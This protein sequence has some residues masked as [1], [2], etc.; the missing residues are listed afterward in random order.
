M[1]PGLPRPAAAFPAV[2]GLIFCL[3]ATLLVL[4]CLAG[5][6]EGR[7]HWR[8][9]PAFQALGV[10]AA[11]R[12]S[13]VGL[14]STPPSA[15]RC[16]LR[17]ANRERR[18]ADLRMRVKEERETSRAEEAPEN[19]SFGAL[20]LAATTPGEVVEASAA[21]PWDAGGKKKRKMYRN[22]C[23]ALAKLAQMLTGMGVASARDATVREPGFVHVCAAAASAA[24]WPQP[25][26]SHEDSC[27]MDEEDARAALGALRALALLAPLHGEALESARAI[28]SII[29]PFA[30]AWPPHTVSAA[31]WAAKTL[32]LD[33]DLAE[34]QPLAQA[35]TVL[36]LPFRISPSM[37]SR[38]P[39]A[40]EN[41]GYISLDTLRAEIPFK[42][43]KLVT[44][45]GTMVEERRAT[46]WMAEDGV[47]GLACNARL[48]PVLLCCISPPQNL[49]KQA[50]T[51]I[52][53]PQRKNTHLKHFA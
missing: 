52:R 2:L 16:G 14:P 10:P 21:I 27:T 18:S 15:N 26:S 44:R 13:L 11:A 40:S 38:V 25:S 28:C 4:V 42:K 33:L 47:G 30:S 43:E 45:Q 12:P 39:A 32:D 17:S 48:L 50:T 37:L 23:A 36:A 51:L 46:C 35:Y 24:R 31:H 5:L 7:S 6:A 34:L 1:P 53:N 3:M 49:E 19:A 29:V 22:A 41:A 9:T 20:V 8:A